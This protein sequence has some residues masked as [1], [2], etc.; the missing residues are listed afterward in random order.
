MKRVL[1][2]GSWFTDLDSAETFLSVR[3]I[4]SKEK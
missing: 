3:F 2:Y 4:L 1:S